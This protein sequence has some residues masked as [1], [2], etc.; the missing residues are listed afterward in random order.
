MQNGCLRFFVHKEFIVDLISKSF[1]LMNFLGKYLSKRCITIT[2]FD[3]KRKGSNWTFSKT[4]IQ[5]I[6]YAFRGGGE[7]S[8]LYVI[9]ESIPKMFSLYDGDK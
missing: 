3:I 5:F 7:C 8:F 9:F 4:Y 2:I 6:K 1:I